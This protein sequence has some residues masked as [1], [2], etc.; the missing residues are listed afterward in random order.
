MSNIP[1]LKN[2]L[3]DLGGVIL[4]LNVNATLEA[5]LHMGFPKELL[6]YPENFY[7]D[8][9]YK[10]ETGKTT[11]GEFRDSIREITKVDFR[12]EDFDRAWN[13]MLARVPLKR[14]SML[15]TLSK[16]FSLYM[17]SNTSPL[18]IERFQQ[19]FRDTAG[20]PL[21]EVFTHCYYSFETG[22]HKP[23]SAA[24][25]D[26]IIS[27]GIKVEETLF[28]DDNIHNVKAAK[29]LGFHV[30]H[31]TNNLKMEDVGYDR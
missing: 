6:N 11:T 12:D 29:E 23:D 25:K 21:S 26:V 5:F 1:S 14:I 22:K 18:H 30:I 13:S 17:L 2:I 27:A 16:K 8:V 7:T 24:F 9:F 20:F 4:D 10:Y 28:L 15:R 31:I 19:M 3:F